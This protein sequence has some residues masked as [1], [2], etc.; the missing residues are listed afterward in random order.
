MSRPPRVLRRS[1][2]AVWALAAT[3]L[4]VFAIASLLVEPAAHA[5][6]TG[7]SR[8]ASIPGACSTPTC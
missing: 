8:A 1:D 5:G 3:L 6:S 2:R 4:T 7:P